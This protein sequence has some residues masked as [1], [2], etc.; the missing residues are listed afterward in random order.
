MQKLKNEYNYNSPI[1]L[2]KYMSINQQST[3]NYLEY[4]KTL[5]NIENLPEDVKV[6]TITVNCEI[7]SLFNTVN[8]GKYIDMSANDIFY[9]K[10][11]DGPDEFREITGAMGKQL[12]RKNIKKDSSGKK[13]TKKLFFNQAQISIK[14]TDKSKATVKIFK[15]GSIQIAG[16][17]GPQN[18][19][20]ILE[21]ICNR[22]KKVKAIIDPYTT[23][24]II[25]KPFATKP[26][27]LTVS[28]IY[29]YKISLINT[30]FLIG[31]YI[32]RE[33]LYKL[34]L[35]ER[36]DCV[37]EPCVHACV[38]IKFISSS[39]VEISIFVFE[40]GSIIITG[41]KKGKCIIEA[42][43][44]ITKFLCENYGE[45]VLTS[46]STLLSIDDIMDIDKLINS[47]S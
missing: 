4:F 26:E 9:V 42:Y 1:I 10:Y 34:L 28:N 6:S 24:K 35:R 3:I 32:N 43:N 40:S 41:A 38:N 19:L 46:I 44:Y 39:G 7:D 20:D 29:G 33:K 15:N 31:F 5:L 13:K 45:I 16:C 30:N 47:V 25:L 22:L 21:I 18:L 23:N 8:I 12:R 27:N 14:F 36:K 17:K 2:F 11:G 37:Y